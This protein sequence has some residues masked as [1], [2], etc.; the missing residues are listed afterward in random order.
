MTKDPI[1]EIE[2]HVVN[3]SDELKDKI[4]NL[5]RKKISNLDDQVNVDFLSSEQYWKYPEE[6]KCFFGVYSKNLDL[7]EMVNLFGVEW[8]FLS[9]DSTA[10]WSKHLKQDVFL[11]NNITWVHTY[12]Y[13]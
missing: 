3:Y 2:L 6:T 10:I 1:I 8:H 11:N 9:D 4:V 5:L 7:K 13:D 12:L